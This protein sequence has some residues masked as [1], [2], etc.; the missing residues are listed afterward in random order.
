MVRKQLHITSKQKQWFEDKANETGLTE[1]ELIR[2]ALDRYM[3][4]YSE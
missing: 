3:E 2:R 1:A 4:H